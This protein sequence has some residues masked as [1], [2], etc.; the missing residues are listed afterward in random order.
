METFEALWL[1]PWYSWVLHD[2]HCTNLFQFVKVDVGKKCI[3]DFWRL[4]H[5]MRRAIMSSSC[6]NDL[7]FFDAAKISRIT[8]TRNYLYMKC[9]SHIRSNVTK[10]I[11]IRATKRFLTDQ[12]QEHQ[13]V[14][15]RQD[16][17]LRW[18]DFCRKTLRIKDTVL[19]DTNY[20]IYIY[21]YIKEKRF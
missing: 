1:K 12:C 2:T 5:A 17:K 7:F 18:N 6:F 13:D 11:I 3:M 21:I 8:Y 20:N 16:D 9:E 19:H 15:K 10:C 14:K 4:S